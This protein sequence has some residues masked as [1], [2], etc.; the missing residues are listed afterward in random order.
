MSWKFDPFIVD[1]VWITPIQTL[2]ELAEINFGTQNN[3]DLEIDMGDRSND[4]SNI[5]Q[6]LRIIDDGNI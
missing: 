3:G 4:I 6:G 2:S 5:D 1:I